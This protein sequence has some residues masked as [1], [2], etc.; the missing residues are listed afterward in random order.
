MVRRNPLKKHGTWG[1]LN[2]K[3]G[4]DFKTLRYV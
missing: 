4:K 3:K 1:Y 2:E